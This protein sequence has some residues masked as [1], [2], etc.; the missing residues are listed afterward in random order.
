MR[1]TRRTGKT[2]DTFSWH[3]SRS[4]FFCCY[5]LVSIQGFLS[6]EL[7]DITLCVVE[8][9]EKTH[10][11]QRAHWPLVTSALARITVF[12]GKRLRFANPMCPL[13]RHCGAIINWFQL[14]GNAKCSEHV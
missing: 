2:P 13:A 8:Y 5:L 7:F 3:A 14:K 4:S 10:Q 9:Y 6:M 1:P 12:A 11:V